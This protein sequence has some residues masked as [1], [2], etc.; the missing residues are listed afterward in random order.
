MYKKAW[1]TCKVVVLRNK[2]VAFL[3]STGCR[4]C[5]RCNDVFERHTPTGSDF[6]QI[7][8]QIVSIRVKKL[9]NT[10]FILLRHNKRENVSLPV[11]VRRSKTPLLSSQL[12]GFPGCLGGVP[13]CSA[14]FG[15]VLC[16][17]GV[18]PESRVLVRAI[19]LA[20][21]VVFICSRQTAF[22]YCRR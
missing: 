21:K 20:P 8:S 13:E 19:E 3:T 12:S 6:A 22:R 17:F 10:N 9:S 7:F 18:F 16:C 14:V 4:R 1:C 11:H 2:P 15:V 5:R